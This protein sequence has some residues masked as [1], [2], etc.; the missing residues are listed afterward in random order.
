MGKSNEIP[1]PIPVWNLHDY[2]HINAYTPSEKWNFILTA[3]D[4]V[5]L[6]SW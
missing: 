1:M 4:P 2:L 6:L 5:N 3:G